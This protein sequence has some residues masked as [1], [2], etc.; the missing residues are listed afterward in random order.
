MTASADQEQL[1]DMVIAV[2]SGEVR[3][4]P[5]IAARLRVLFGIVE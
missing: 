4:V 5:E 3:E 2:A 1:Y